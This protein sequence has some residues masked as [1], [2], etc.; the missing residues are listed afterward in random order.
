MRDAFAELKSR[1]QRGLLIG[2]KLNDGASVYY[3][4]QQPEKH[5]SVCAD[6]VLAS[7]DNDPR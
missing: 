5:I 6:S 4:R 3:H 2:G 1:A 7:S